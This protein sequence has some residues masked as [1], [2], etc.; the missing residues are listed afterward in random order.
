MK[1][2]HLV[3]ANL[4]LLSSHCIAQLSEPKSYSLKK[5]YGLQGAVKE[6]TTYIC[7]VSGKVIPK[8]TSKFSGKYQVTFDEQGNGLVN[9]RRRTTDKGLVITEELIFHGKGK[10]I[11]YNERMFI[12]GKKAEV[13]DYKYIWSDD[14]HYKVVKQSDTGD[15]QRITLSNNYRLVKVQS[16]QGEIVQTSIYQDLIKKNRIEK[17][18]TYNESKRVKSV[19]VMVMKEFDLHNN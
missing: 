2:T 15:V 9:L 17:T 12:G 1:I 8:D 18:I 7:K 5:E 19:D 11:T 4:L 16:K 14:L 3:L 13:F 10:N 6:V